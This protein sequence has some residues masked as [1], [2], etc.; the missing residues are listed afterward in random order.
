M[1]AQLINFGILFFAFKY[2]VG[3]KLA[4]AIMTRREELKKAE[5]ASVLYDELLSKA[6]QEKKKLIDEGVSH[7]Q[8]LVE[9]AKIVAE[10]KADNI[11]MQAKKQ[12]EHIEKAAHEKAQYL[13][14]ELKNNFV[15]GVKYTA[16]RVVRKL[17]DKDIHLEEQYLEQLAQEA[18][19]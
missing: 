15:S 4:K 8:K 17:F 16:H 19:K 6:E 3:D 2:L 7:K 10:K 18:V 11:V 9:E 14:S 1:I 13:E 5:N 12:A